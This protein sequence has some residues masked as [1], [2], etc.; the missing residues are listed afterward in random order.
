M[1]TLP[2]WYGGSLFCKHFCPGLTSKFGNLLI[3]GKFCAIE[4]ACNFENLPTI[5]LNPSYYLDVNVGISA[6]VHLSG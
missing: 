3:S 5:C 6:I 1:T 4:V 2:F